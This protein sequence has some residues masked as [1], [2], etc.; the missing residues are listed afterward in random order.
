[1]NVP[2]FAEI[3]KKDTEFPLIRAIYFHCIMLYAQL[4]HC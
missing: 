4:Y 2:N 1:M 3:L